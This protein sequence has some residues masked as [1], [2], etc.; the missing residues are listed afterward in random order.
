MNNKQSLYCSNCTIGTETGDGVVSQHE[1]QALKEVSELKII[2]DAEKLRKYNPNND[3][4]LQ[5]FFARAII[6]NSSEKIDIAHFYGGP[7]STTFEYLHRQGTKIAVTMPAHDRK[8]SIEEHEKWYGVGSF[9][10]SHI[11]DDFLWEAYTEHIKEADIII[12]PSRHS[13]KNILRDVGVKKDKI[14]L[15]PHGVNL[16]RNEEIKPIPEHFTV[17]FLSQAGIDKGIPYLIQAWSELAYND[18]ELLLA[19]SGTESLE[20]LVKQLA[21][22]GQFRLLGRV[23]NVA[24]VYN[25]CSAFILAS[26]NEGFGVP[27]VEAMSYSRPVLTAAGC[28]ASDAVTDGKDGF[29]VPIRNPKAIADKIQWFRD[30]PE[31]VQRMGA[32]AHKKAEQYSWD[33]IREKYKKIYRKMLEKGK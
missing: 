24:E 29:I 26:T 13:K 8:L 12:A 6:K 7:Y 21:A 16:P 1:L 18:A 32:N 4:W 25:A 20:P 2:L 28:G 30:N 33:K 17:V 14:M 3:V 27:L 19:G 10:F 9:P 31:E 15:V 11:K 5:D 23:P 22:N